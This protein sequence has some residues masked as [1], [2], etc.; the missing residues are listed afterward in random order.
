[1]TNDTLFRSTLCTAA[2]GA[3]A[4]AGIIGDQ[5]LNRMQ[6]AEAVMFNPPSRHPRTYSAQTYSTHNMDRHLDMAHVLHV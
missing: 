4:E 3:A 5:E 2:Q 1:M 6:V